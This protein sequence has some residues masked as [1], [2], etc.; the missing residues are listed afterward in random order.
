MRDRVSTDAIEKSFE[1]LA[2]G[3][4]HCV[5]RLAEKRRLGVSVRRDVPEPVLNDHVS[6]CM[7]TVVED[8]GAGYAA[9]GD[10]SEAGLELA[11]KDARDRAKLTASRRLFDAARLPIPADRSRVDTRPKGGPPTIS[12]CLAMTS[13][14][15]RRIKTAAT[16]ARAMDKI[17]DWSAAIE[18]AECHSLLLS[19]AGARI[20][21]SYGY[22]SPG[23]SVVARDH[24]Q[25]QQRSHGDGHM[26]RQ[27]GLEQLE[28][29]GFA[30]HGERLVDEALA[31]LRAPECPTRKTDLLLMPGQMILQLHESIGHPL[32]LDRILGDE[33]NYAGGSFV[34]PEMI[35]S[36]QYGAECL[37]VVFDPRV[38][39]ELASYAYDDDGTRAERHHLIKDGILVGAIG[40]ASSS[41]RAGIP[42][43]AS[44]RA[45]SW[46]RAPIDRMG[47]INL[48]PGDHGLDALLA[49]VEQGVLMDTNRSWSIDHLRNKFQ[50]GCEIGW[51]I[52]DGQRKGLVRNPGYRGVSANFWRSLD[53]VGDT[54]TEAVL[55]TLDCGKGEPNQL[56]QVGHSAPAC[57]FR[58][59]Q[60]FGGG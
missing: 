4:D 49:S 11:I 35:G 34:T 44:S 32:E 17:A 43:A 37:N 57:V 5:F 9:T 58:N 20:E 54:S 12:E 33:R 40:S 41:L 24:G 3:I 46:N 16:D 56:M 29:V 45:S 39:S 51:L 7:L 31:L 1:R 26:A 14:A 18:A 8:G 19:S 27:G 55:G 10:L 52:E 60:V 6:G 15:S 36:Y 30:E 47:N 13:D 22:V 53:R 2:Q 25:S 21:Q 50:F 38:P 48:L 23:L 28:V 42:A 59:V